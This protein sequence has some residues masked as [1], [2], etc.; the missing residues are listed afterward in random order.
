MVLNSCVVF[1]EKELPG[2][3]VEGFELHVPRLFVVCNNLLSMLFVWENL[4]SNNSRVDQ[5][6]WRS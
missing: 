1:R 4:G 2:I 6:I 5:K 3:I